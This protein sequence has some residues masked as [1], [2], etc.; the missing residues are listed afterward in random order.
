LI[1]VYGIAKVIIRLPA[2][3]KNLKTAYLTFR[4]N[5][6]HIDPGDLSKIENEANKIF[7][8]AD[9]AG[10]EG[11]IVG[12]RNKFNEAELA[13]FEKQIEKAGD[14]ADAPKRQAAIADIESQ[15]SSQKENAALVAELKKANPNLSNKEIA[16]LAKSRIK[17]PN[18][19]HGMTAEEFQ[20]AQDLIKKFLNEKGLKDVEG[21]AT[22]SRITGVTFNPK[23]AKAAK[24]GKISDLSK[25]DLDI[26]LVTPRELKRGEI[27]KLKELYLARFKHPL[28][29]SNISDKRQ[30]AYK[31]VYGKIDLNLK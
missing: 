4:S 21:F 22:G 8:Q 1:G 12:L 11:E 24:F 18:V 15:I 14:I 29:V 26:T 6:A 13:A 3:F 23:G 27:D 10:F 9:K 28:G 2:T 20:E 5:A 16:E 17:V 25:S 31:P 7:I 19:P 30:L